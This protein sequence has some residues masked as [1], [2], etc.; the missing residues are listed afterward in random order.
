VKPLERHDVPLGVFNYS[1]WI[2]PKQINSISLT[3]YRGR[4][5]CEFCVKQFSGAGP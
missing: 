1:S 5:V 3:E 2:N 4:E